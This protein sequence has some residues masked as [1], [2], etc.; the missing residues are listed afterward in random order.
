MTRP[1]ERL[2]NCVIIVIT[3]TVI[4]V[5]IGHDSNYCINCTYILYLMSV[6][7]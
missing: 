5:I 2:Y 7:F 4:I 3:V 1:L 6:T